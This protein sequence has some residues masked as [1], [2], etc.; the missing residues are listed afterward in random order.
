MRVPPFYAAFC[1]LLLLGF[2]YAKLR[3]LQ[4]LPE[5]GGVAAQS[6]GGT[7]SSGSGGGFFGASS[8]HK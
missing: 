7:G 1:L 4:Y 8:S 6:S 5:D 3:G 2:A